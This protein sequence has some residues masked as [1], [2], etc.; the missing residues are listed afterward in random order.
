MTRLFTV[1]ELLAL[2]A[3]VAFGFLWLRNPNGPFE[4]YAFMATLVGT[5]AADAARRKNNAS[6]ALSAMNTA[7]AQVITNLERQLSSVLSHLASGQEQE[8]QKQLSQMIPTLVQAAV[9]EW[10][11]GQRG[12]HPAIA[13][14]LARL[15]PLTRKSISEAYGVEP[16]GS[17]AGGMSI[18][19]AK[20]WRFPR[21]D[22]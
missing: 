11:S 18:A 2:L 14:E 12:A 1:I 17:P 20:P 6:I 5:T 9:D 13:E 8:L 22:D 21:L 16:A 7:A 15:A 3:A 19:D 10:K 4:P